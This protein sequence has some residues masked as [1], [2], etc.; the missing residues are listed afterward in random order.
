MI[1]PEITQDAFLSSLE[2]KLGIDYTDE[3]RDLIKKFGDG[4]IF[5]F[6]DPGTGK[7][8]TAIGGLIN[9]ELFKQ[10]PGD[11]IYALSF[12]RL[13]TAE[14]ATRFTRACEKLR[15]QRTIHFQTLHA[16]CKQIL[17]E[18]YRLLG[19]T[20][21]DTTGALTMEK[22]RSIIE[23][24]L[25]DWGEELSV[26][27]IKAVIRAI[28][29]LNAAL[30]FDEDSV[31]SKMAFKECG[32]E[33][34]LF[35]KL[36]GIM[37]AYNLLTETISVSDLL[38]YTV[39]L[40]QRHPEVSQAFKQK[41]KLLLVDEAQDLSL[42][43]LRVISMLTDNPVCIGDM[44]QQIYAFNGACQEVVSEFHRL[45]PTAV[46]CKLTQSFRC[47][48][49]I[50]DYAT[51]IILP[52]KVGGED[53][54]GTGEGGEVHVVNGLYEQGLD[55]VGL[56]ERLHNEF[57]LNR[58]TFPK[59]YLFVTRNNV[60][61][62]PVMEELYKQ[63][64]PFRVNKFAPAYEVPVIKEM[65]EL[66]NLCA[67][68]Q[69]YRNVNALKYLIPEFRPYSLEENPYYIICKKTACSIFEVNYS[70][71]NMEIGEAAMETLIEVHD[72]IKRGA[73]TGE[74]FNTMWQL[75]YNNYVRPYEWKF[76]AKPEYYIQSVNV[77]TRKPYQ[78]FIQ[79]EIR[80][81]AVTEESERYQRGIRCYTMH[82]SKGLEADC[83]FI[84]DANDGL[85]PNVSKLNDM[86]KKDCVLDAARAIREERS[87]CYVACTRARE[88]LYII[89]TSENPAPLLIGE[90]PYGMYDA[91]FESNSVHTDDIAAFTDFTERYVE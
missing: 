46:D 62:I 39:M 6:A 22:A 12:T 72:Q 27:K 91:V 13:A 11:H 31:T 25:R 55:I 14:M 78:Q 52:N 15:S 5:C 68:P 1:L 56:S 88:E 45:F 21:F 47:K 77:L 67:D 4:P 38:L 36:R 17:K 70:F 29:S 33:Y 61:L 58:N 80:K 40:L 54:K 34:E 83:V 23:T 60:S 19:M 89:Y 9:S 85:I 82:A 26:N 84:I 86:I 43:Q 87:L 32:I 24:T 18:N 35:E 71:K 37:F 57:V 7:T 49:N 76:E 44:K 20:K 66:L 63:G 59:E 2:V 41:C 10:I 69:D 90:N 53:Y 74:L 65:C 79:D 81:K 48:N 42:L 8:F 3:Q 50:A 28:T 30:I 64:L 75:Y 16:L 73:T 51:K